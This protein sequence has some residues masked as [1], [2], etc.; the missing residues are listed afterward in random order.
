MDLSKYDFKAA[1][2]DF[3]GTL[4]K[5][6]SIF[7]EQETVEALI[8]LGIK[9]PIAF[10]TGRQL[11]SFEKRC[12]SRILP[13]I[14]PANREDFL[15]NVYLM[16]ENGAIGYFFNTD[17]DRFEE[18][19]RGVWPNEFIDRKKLKDEL[20]EVIKDVGEVYRDDQHSHEVVIVLKSN[21]H[22]SGDAKGIAQLSAKMYQKSR[23]Y[24]LNKDKNFEKYIHIGDSGL[25]VVFCPADYDKDSAI[26]R[27]ADFLN[28]KG[29][30]IDENAR[31]IM[32]VGDNPQKSG[33]DYYFLNGRYGTPF[34][35]GHPAEGNIQKAVFDGQ[36]KRLF[37]DTA[38]RI[39][40]NSLLD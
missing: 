33:N 17:L 3:D 9:M 36:N 13:E 35:V 8:A 16:G 21:L 23:D 37:N 2:F 10:C 6:G 22:N 12:L 14:P 38:T 39:L 25:G 34:N 32:V 29:L 18:F 15:E 19:Y 7:P 11:K 1:M 4:T 30:E 27:F 31:K 24:L 20:D 5:K 28:K 40:I 26:I